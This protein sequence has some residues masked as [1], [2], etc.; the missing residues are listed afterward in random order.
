MNFETLLEIVNSTLPTTTV[1]SSMDSVSP[2]KHDCVYLRS[3]CI[4]QLDRWHSLLE[5]GCISQEQYDQFKVTI[6]KDIIMNF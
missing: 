2:S 5:K 6:L 4:S 3:E 1:Q